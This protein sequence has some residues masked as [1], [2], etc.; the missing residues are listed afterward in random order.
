[1]SCCCVH[2]D[3]QIVVLASL[4]HSYSNLVQTAYAYCRRVGC[5]NWRVCVCLRIRVRKCE[6]WSGM[7]KKDDGASNEL[8]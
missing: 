5:Q 4:R 3:K 6:H 7:D 1:M 2:Q 8:R